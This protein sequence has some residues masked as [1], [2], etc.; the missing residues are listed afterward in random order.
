VTGADNQV[1]LE[2]VHVAAIDTTAA[3]D[4]F[5]G[6]FATGLLLWNEPFKSAR[7]AIAAA[8][9]SVTRFGAQAS[10]ATMDE[11]HELLKRARMLWKNDPVGVVGL[12][13][14]GSVAFCQLALLE[15]LC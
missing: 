5:S 3:G 13:G 8:G 14:T 11:V 10:M 15:K 12:G 2:S 4:A 1:M 9:V 6:A 7:F